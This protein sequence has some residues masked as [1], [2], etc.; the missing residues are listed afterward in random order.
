MERTLYF[1][2]GFARY[3]IRSPATG[4]IVEKHIVRGERIDTESPVFTIADMRTVWVNLAVHLKDLHAITVGKTVS[5]RADYSGRE[6]QGQVTM[7]SPIVDHE[8]RTASAR[9]VL[10][11]TDG[12]WRPGLFVVGRIAVSTQSIPVIVP[13]NAV[14][15]IEGKTVVFIPEGDAFVP[16]PVQTGRSDREHIE[17]TAGLAPGTQFVTEGAYE[18]KAKL[19]TSNLGSHAGHGH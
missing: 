2:N 8:T 19:V 16:T 15:T 18:L 6:A 7:V 11:N 14:Q 12:S 1:G 3:E 10:D 4:V 5:I 17:I 9:L 13:K